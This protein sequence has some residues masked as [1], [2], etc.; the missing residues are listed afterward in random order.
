MTWIVVPVAIYALVCL[1]VFLFQARLVYFPDRALVATPAHIGLEYEEV[2]FPTEDGLTLHGWFVPARSPRGVLLFCHGNAGHISHRLD[3]IRIFVELGLSVFIFDYRGY[4]KSEGSPGER[5]TYR[6]ATAAYRYLTVT[7]GVL[8][9]EILFFGRSL[10][11]AVAVELA[12]RSA[13]RALLLESVFTSAPDLG[14][15]VYPWLPVRW[16]ARISYDSKGRIGRL[17]TPLLSIHSRDDEIV[18]ISH[19]RRLYDLAAD[20]KRFLELR[21][22]HNEGFLVSE[23][24][25]R[26]GLAAFLESLTPIPD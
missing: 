18:P 16:L 21:G 26:E 22:G 2:L 7:T 6:D 8:S 20:P 17:R 3:S 23:P 19:G 4:G 1:L 5:G 24:Q 14:A 11:G 13:P 12:T 9:E 15:R 10:G 25:Y